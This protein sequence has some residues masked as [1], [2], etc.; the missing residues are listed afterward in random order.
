MKYIIVILSLLMSGSAFAEEQSVTLSV[1]GM[2]CPV[3]PIT[4]KKAIEKV[5]GVKSTN[6]SYENKLA[7]VLYDDQLADIASIQEATKNVGYL[8]EVIKGKK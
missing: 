1:P 3:C 8:S 7:T 4:V 5:T 2:N 6:V